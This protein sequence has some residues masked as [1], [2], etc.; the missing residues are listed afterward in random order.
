[1][2]IDFQN[3]AYKC[4]IETWKRIENVTSEKDVKQYLL[5]LVHDDIRADEYVGRENRHR[6]EQYR[7]RA[8]FYGLASQ[9]LKGMVGSVFRKPPSINVPAGLEYVNDN[10]DGAGNSIQQQSRR[11]VSETASKGRAGLV[12]RYPQTDGQVSQADINSGKMVATVE[13]V[14]AEQITNWDWKAEGSKIYLTLVVIAEKVKERGD[15][16]YSYEEKDGFRELALEDGVYVERL[17]VE[18]EKEGLFVV[19]DEFVPTKADGSKWSEIP[20]QFI[21]SENN[22]FHVDDAPMKSM[23]NINIG[24]YRNSADYEYSVF[25]CGMAQPVISGASVDDMKEVREQGFML[26][27]GQLLTIGE[28]GKFTF[29]QAKENPMVRQAMLDKVDQMVSLGARMMS[30]GSAAKT[31]TQVDSEDAINH[32]VISLVA[33]NVS[34]AYTKVLGW[35]CEYMN[36]EQPDDMEYVLNQDFVQIDTQP[37]ELQ[38]I[39]NLFRTGA[40]PVGD[41]IA[42]MKRRGYFREDV[43]TDEYIEMLSQDVMV[44][45]AV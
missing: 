31:A 45:G 27:A 21:G 2:G 11:V 42:I 39:G 10:I 33:A 35:M 17:W 34:E 4:E 26:G 32:S 18:S 12:V 22:D 37:Q 43:S 38:I 29:E 24:H 6:N 23:C 14:E 5:D 19:K 30:Q 36:I 7:N 16:G 20:F 8:V 9:T 40:I 13:R 25:F 3:P 1:M 28:G 44:E 41:Y 15:D